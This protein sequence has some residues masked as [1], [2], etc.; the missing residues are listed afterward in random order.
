MSSA[1]LE[2]LAAD[3]SPFAV[4]PRSLELL[5]AALTKLDSPIAPSWGRPLCG[6]VGKIKSVDRALADE[7]EAGGTKSL[8][9]MLLEADWL[10]TRIALFYVTPRLESVIWWKWDIIT[11]MSAGRERWKFSGVIID[12]ADGESL[13]LRTSRDAAKLLL[14]L[15]N[16]YVSEPR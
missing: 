2:R 4:N 1:D 10:A 13:E 11:G 9:P 3:E 12:K 14:A 8:N 16:R 6:A 5:R 15:G 7:A